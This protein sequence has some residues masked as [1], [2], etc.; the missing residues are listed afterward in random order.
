MYARCI[1]MYIIIIFIFPQQTIKK[2]CQQSN[3]L[4]CP[5]Q[6]TELKLKSDPTLLP[7][8]KHTY[9][10]KSSQMQTNKVALSEI[11]AEANESD[12]GVGYSEESAFSKTSSFLSTL[13][14]E[15]SFG[16]DE[17]RTEEHCIHSELRHSSHKS[18][19]K[20]Q[21]ISTKKFFNR[22]AS[23]SSAG[24]IALADLATTV[25]S[26]TN[27]ELTDINFKSCSVLISSNVVVSSES[28]LSSGKSMPFLRFLHVFQ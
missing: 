5:S 12:A 11:I 14:R 27:K 22:K 13:V 2:S 9:G 17:C 1:Y 28:S 4:G 25:P 3:T 15:Q 8:F 7:H 20:F 10:I 23:T 16:N 19:E 26:S 21:R 24:S 6:E 18:K